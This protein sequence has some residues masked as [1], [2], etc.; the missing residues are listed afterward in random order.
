LIKKTLKTEARSPKN[1]RRAPIANYY[2]AAKDPSAQS[3]FRRKQAKTNRRMVLFNIADILLLAVVIIG[4]IYSLILRHDPA[5]KA[6]SVQYHSA[7]VYKSEIAP[8]FSGLKNS[9]KLTFDEASVV[10]AIQAKFPEVR[11]ARVELPFFSE[12]P[13]AWLSISPPAFSLVNDQSSYLI[14]T[15]GVAVARSSDIPAIKNKVVVQDQ[16]SFNVKLGQQIL[17]SDGVSLI[18]TVIAQATQAKVPISTLSLPPRAQELDLKTA[19]QPY[20]VRF[21]LAGDALNQTGQFLAARHQFATSGKSPSQY[22][23]VRVPGKI[24]YK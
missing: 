4:L 14:D 15:Q 22:L 5:I 9:N 11:S 24:F 13:V 16:T 19:D 8:L 7:A 2:R 12:Q 20:Y 21:Y 10:R 1:Y 23:D 18:N 6:D 17:S 3:P